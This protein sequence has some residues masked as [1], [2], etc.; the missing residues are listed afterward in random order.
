M[1][2]IMTDHNVDDYNQNQDD[3][4]DNSDDKEHY[5][6]CETVTKDENANNIIKQ[7]Q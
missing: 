1:Q 5:A 6:N 2:L 7:Q 4:D 3:I